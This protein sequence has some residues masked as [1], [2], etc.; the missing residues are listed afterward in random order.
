MR[1]NLFAG[2]GAG[3]STLASWLF[4]ELKL[5]DYSIELVS[6]YVKSW[7]IE[8]R[9]IHPFHQVYFMGRQLEYEYRFL[10]NGVKH[11]IT[12]SPVFLAATYAR[13]YNSHLF[14][15]AN[16]MESIIST[17]EKKHPAINIFLNRG[18]YFQQEGR[19]H[20]RE[21]AENIDRAVLSTLISNGVEFKEFNA[22]DRQDILKHIIKKIDK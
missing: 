19:Y 16:Q 10:T 2:P 13:Y 8:K 21:Q 20:N 15:V 7:A 4:A 1:I 9:K 17:Y 11:I 18:D 22:E 6:E 14:E 3:K 12:D 5:R